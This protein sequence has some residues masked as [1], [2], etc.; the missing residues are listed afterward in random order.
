MSNKGIIERDGGKGKQREGSGV[1]WTQT[2]ERERENNLLHMSMYI[3]NYIIV[4]RGR[5]RYMK[6][7][8]KC[9]VFFLSLF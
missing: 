2:R 3:K 7:K 6:Q 5:E 8:K 4:G 1:V 9:S